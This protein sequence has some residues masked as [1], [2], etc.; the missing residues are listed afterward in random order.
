MGDLL[1][2]PGGV[3]DR[4]VPGVGP[5]VGG[6]G[7]EE[8]SSPGRGS[9]SLTSLPILCCEAELCGSFTPASAQAFIVSPE[10]S[11]V[12]GPA[13]PNS[14]VSPSCSLAKASA[15]SPGGGRRRRRG[16][17]CGADPLQRRPLGSGDPTRD[18]QRGARLEPLHGR[19]GQV[20]VQGGARQLAVPEGPQRQLQ[21]S[22]VGATVAVLQGGAGPCAMSVDH[23]APFVRP[24]AS[25]PCWRWND[26]SFFASAA[27]NDR[28]RLAG[29]AGLAHRHR[30]HVDRR[31]HRRSSKGLSLRR[32]FGWVAA[33]RVSW[34]APKTA[35]RRLLLQEVPEDPVSRGP[36]QV[37]STSRPER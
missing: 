6:S 15:T 28:L 2:G 5:D 11:H 29:L 4:A 12:S 19:R 24:V 23:V 9:A 7:G 25:R 8:P 33:L 18:R 31:G 22:H 10:Q 14:Y 16:R 20:A 35:G 1:A 37:S 27:E 21:A 32:R 17:G 13:A 36:A 30:D 34:D 3:H 26:D